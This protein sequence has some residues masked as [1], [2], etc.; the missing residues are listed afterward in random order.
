MTLEEAHLRDLCRRALEAIELDSF[1]ASLI[2]EL[3]EASLADL[4]PIEGL[5]QG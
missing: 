4:P 2:R 1:T 5:P 3:R